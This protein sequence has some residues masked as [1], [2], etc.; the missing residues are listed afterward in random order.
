MKKT[1]FLGSALLTGLSFTGQAMA[2]EPVP[3]D[4]KSDYSV[5]QE[6][7]AGGM[8]SGAGNYMQNCMPCHGMEGKGDGPLAADLGGDIRPRDLTNAALLSSRSDE[9][10]FKVIKFG[11]KKSGLSDVM[12]DWGYAFDDA[13]IKS[14][15]HYMRTELCKCKYEGGK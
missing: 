4:V 10:L 6:V 11:G 14:I 2:E 7:W 1:L 15:V 8:H 13:G 5:S 9:F 12:P 3:P